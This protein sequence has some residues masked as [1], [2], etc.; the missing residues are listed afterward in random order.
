LANLAGATLPVMIA[1]VTVPLYLKI[2]GVERYGVLAIIWALLG[3][4]GFLDLGLG[5]AVTQR[6]ARHAKGNAKDRSNLLWT[7]LVA[8]FLLGLAGSGVLWITA[9]YLLTH[10]VESSGGIRKEA[11][12]AVHWLLF[13]LPIILPGSALT[14]ALQARLR[15]VQLNT[16][17]VF[18]GAIG[19]V[20]PLLVA[21]GG[22]VELRYLVPAVLV[23]RI[24]SILLMF[25]QCRRYVPLIG[26]PTIDRT[27][28]RPMLGYGGWFSILS[29]LAPLLVTIDR[30]V[31]ASIS[32][33]RAVAH[34][35]VP[36]DLVSRLMILSGSLSSAIFPRLA[37]ADIDDGRL[38]AQRASEAL[39]SI[40]T[41]I[42]IAGLVLAGPFISLWVGQEFAA[43]SAGVAEFILLG[44]WFNAI[45]VPHHARYLAT[46]SPKKVVL[47]YAIEIP[48]YF[49]ILWYG[50]LNWGVAGAAAAWC[51][52][53]C[54]DTVL[55]LRL[56]QVL[57]T[58]SRMVLPSLLLV[59]AAGAFLILELNLLIALT[60]SAMLLALSFA[61]DRKVL[62][63]ILQR[64]LPQRGA[65]F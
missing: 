62:L 44:V 27:H 4:F 12:T 53:V 34:Y 65:A 39:V 55:L 13:A 61:K 60:L 42:T 7:A 47:I 30:L 6:M 3:Y 50:I 54:L 2:I 22:Y 24:L 36:Y 26:R 63:D 38:L 21:A 59:M 46:N 5:R 43:A 10:V 37:S 58:T 15:F 14:G 41:P 45:V 48:L 32:G 17:Q 64:F 57:A 1:L 29:L 23:S 11:Q 51:L 31:I 9:S 20:L 8:A 28:L 25:A 56:N 19:Q 52:R 18:C 33:A 16:I 35:T 40:M 49:A